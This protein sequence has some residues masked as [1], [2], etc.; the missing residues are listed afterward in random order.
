MEI[1]SSYLLC[2]D[3][4]AFPAFAQEAMTDMVKQ[5]GGE[6]E[7][8]RIKSG[9][10]PLLSRPDDVVAWIRKVAGEEV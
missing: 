2:E 1:P 7:V 6:M 10:S 9:H 8:D 5:K 4:L 3:D